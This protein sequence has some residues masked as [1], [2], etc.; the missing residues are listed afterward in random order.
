MSNGFH[1]QKT[2]TKT[3]MAKFCLFTSD[4][5]AITH[6]KRV[7]RC[8]TNFPIIFIPGQDPNKYDTIFFNKTFH[9]YRLVPCCTFH[10]K[11]P[12]EEKKH[13]YCVQQLQQKKLT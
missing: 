9:V 3:V 1:I 8:C 6:C 5:H 7:L 11:C 13:V 10:R 12:Y 4:Q 2:S